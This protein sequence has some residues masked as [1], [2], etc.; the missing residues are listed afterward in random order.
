M[1]CFRWCAGLLFMGVLGAGCGGEP[2]AEPA[3]PT[4]QAVVE[5]PPLPAGC[6]FERGV[7]TCVTVTQ[8]QEVSTHTETSGC[9]V[10]PSLPPIPGRRLRTFQDVFLVTETTTTLQ[11]GRAGKVFD[12]QTT[13]DRQLVSSTLISDVCEP[14]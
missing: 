14:L 13:T 7:T 6:T 12:T 4:V 9:V 11:H 2:L 3:A 5:A 10:G 1:V 8:R